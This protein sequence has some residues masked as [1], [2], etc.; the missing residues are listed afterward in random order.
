MAGQPKGELIGE[1]D[2][3]PGVPGLQR[4]D[5]E[6]LEP[7]THPA[8]LTRRVDDHPNALGRSEVGLP[9]ER[10]KVRIGL[11]QRLDTGHQTILSTGGRSRC[12]KPISTTPPPSLS[13]KY[14]F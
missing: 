3:R 8:L 4:G 6:L 9:G 2:D 14:P 5:L 13:S 11:D 1:V 10:H 7:D 12:R